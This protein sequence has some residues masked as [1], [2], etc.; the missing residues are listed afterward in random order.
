MP[1]GRAWAI[2]VADSGETFACLVDRNSIEDPGRGWTTDGVASLDVLPRQLR[3]REVV[4]VE[5]SGVIQHIRVASLDCALWTG[6]A[7]AFDVE[8]TDGLPH[9][10]QTIFTRSER[11]RSPHE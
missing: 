2:Y 3:P 7:T 5:E 8:G 1:R 9:L 11:R 10:C 4:G 6:E